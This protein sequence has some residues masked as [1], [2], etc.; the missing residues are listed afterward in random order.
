MVKNVKGGSS[1]KSQA[2]K[3][4][5]SGVS[6]LSKTRLA[7]EGEK[8]AQ[9]IKLLGNGMCHVLCDDEIIRLCIIRGKFKFRGRRDNNVINN[10]WILVGL[11]DF[12]TEKTSKMGH[13]DLLEIYSDK[14]KEFLKVQETKINWKKFISNDNMSI[15]G[16]TLGEEKEEYFVF[17]DEKEEEYNEIREKSIKEATSTK[18]DLNIGASIDEDLEID[19][20][21][22]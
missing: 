19:I 20:D 7:E 16:T 18:I 15:S 10:S 17:S 13:C 5:Q 22:I 21:D 3:H 12:E 9:V 1:H 2:R 11:R 14:D 4:T 6:S 8:Y